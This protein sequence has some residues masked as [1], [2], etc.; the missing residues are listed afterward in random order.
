MKREFRGTQI[1]LEPN[2]RPYLLKRILADGFDIAAIF[3]LFMLFTLLQPLK[4]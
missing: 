4:A 1:E 2:S 3:A